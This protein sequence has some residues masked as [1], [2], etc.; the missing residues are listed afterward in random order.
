MLNKTE[1]ILATLLQ[2][3]PPYEWRG[4]NKALIESRAPEVIAEGGAETGKSYAACYKAHMA[5]R[6]YPKAQGALIRKVSASIPGTILQTMRRIIGTFPVD[7]FGGENNPERIIYPNGSTIW[8]GGM[9]NPTKALSGERDFVQVCQSEELTIN[10]WEILTTRVTGRGAVM[11]YTQLFGDC[12]PGGAKHH[13]KMREKAGSLKMCHTRLE[14]NPSLYDRQGNPTEQGKRTLARLGALTGI[15]KKRLLDGI[16]ASPEGLIYDNFDEADVIPR[17]AIPDSW[18]RYVGL[19]FGLVN[20]A[21]CFYANEPGT[22]RYYLYRTYHGGGFSVAA[23]VQQILRGEK[24]IPFCVGG[25]KSEGNWRKEFRTNGLTVREPDIKLVEVGI[26]RVY[27]AHA[28]HEIKVFDDCI[29]YLDQKRTYSR[30]LDQQGLPTEKIAD[31]ETFHLL[32]CERYII[33]YLKRKGNKAQSSTVDF[34][35]QPKVKNVIIPAHNEQEIERML[36]EY[37]HE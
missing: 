13:L 15:R 9:D 4:G 7:Y 23:H 36:E 5:C 20:L 3:D 33:G 12:N 2:Y 8:I 6:E 17:F 28:N 34:Y 24:Q 25:A 21:A 14:D 35:A 37:T 26:D 18:M 10:D 32:D 31:K 30:E 22:D 16:W 29:E 1:T 27:G 19:D 11:P